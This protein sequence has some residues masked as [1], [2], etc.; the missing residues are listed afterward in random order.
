MIFSAKAP[1]KG[2]NVLSV[3]NQNATADGWQQLQDL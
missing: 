1:K 3:L 2:S